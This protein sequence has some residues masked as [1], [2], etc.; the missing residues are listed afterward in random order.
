MQIACVQAGVDYNDLP[1]KA[2]VGEVQAMTD[3]QTYQVEGREQCFAVLHYEGLNRATCRDMKHSVYNGWL[4]H[5]Q[6][7]LPRNIVDTLLLCNKYHTEARQPR[8][9]AASTMP[10]VAY[11]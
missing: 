4:L 3:L 6:D 2:K 1:A 7:I 10:G 5:K 8:V 9:A 11:I